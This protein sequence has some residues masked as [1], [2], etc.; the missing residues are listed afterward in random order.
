MVLEPGENAPTVTAL[1]QDGEDV[2]LAFDAPTVL[3]FY[4]RDATPGCATEARQF[5][6]ELEEYRDAGVSVYGA[7]TDDVDS[8]REFRDDEG[9]DFDL[10]ADPDGELADA[11]DVDR[12]RGAT[13][14]TTFVL[15]DGEVQS[16]YEGVDPDG[17]AREVLEDAL[18]DGLVTLSEL[19]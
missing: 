1:D 13:E 10:L 17:H 3:Y 15:A 12:T 6:R 19:D 18:E 4:P 16:V 2:E 9:L 5:D 7:S 14:R 8:H 11:F